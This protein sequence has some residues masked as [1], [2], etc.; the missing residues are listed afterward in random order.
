[1]TRSRKRGVMSNGSFFKKEKRRGFNSDEDRREIRADLWKIESPGKSFG[2]FSEVS[3][4]HLL[5]TPLSNFKLQ[6]VRSFVVGFS[7][8]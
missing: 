3:N 7:W 2:T 6:K 4:D 5:V 8:L 1:M